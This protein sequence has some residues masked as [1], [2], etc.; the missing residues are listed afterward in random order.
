[1]TA[2]ALAPPLCREWVFTRSIGIPLIVG[3]LRASKACLRA[4]LM[5]P[6]V[7]SCCQLLL[8]Y[9][10]V[11]VLL[12]APFFAKME[13]LSAQCPDGAVDRVSICLLIDADSLPTILLVVQFHGG[14]FCR[15]NQVH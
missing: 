12:V 2:K 7:T 10:K 5:C 9:A 6:E 8:K 14:T 15:H 1:M 11:M 13:I 4:E 3:Y